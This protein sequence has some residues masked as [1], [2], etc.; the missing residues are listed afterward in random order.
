VSTPLSLL[1]GAELPGP[2]AIENVRRAALDAL[3]AAGWPS[4][5]REAWRYTDLEPLSRASLDLKPSPAAD[6]ALDVARR[7]LHS[8]ATDVRDRALVLVDGRRVATLDT[9]PSHELEV[10]DPAARWSRPQTGNVATLPADR[11]PLAAVNT[12]FTEDGLWLRVPAGRSVDRP[13]HLVVLA[14]GR[15]DLAAQPR[16]V[17][18]VEQDARIALVLHFV[19][20]APGIPGWVNSVTEVHQA[21]RSKLELYRYQ[22]HGAERTH[23]SLLAAKLASD[24]ELTAFYSDLG[25]ALVR[26]DIEVEL[27]GRGASATLNGVF[28]AGAGQHVDNHTV[29]DHAA[30]ET[31]SAEHFRGI[32][33]QRG[34][35][36][37]N[38]KVIVRP[39][40][41]RI[42]A[43]QRSDN[44]LLGEHAEI[45]A[46]PELEIYA[47]DVKCSHGTTVGELDE[48]HLFYLRSRGIGEADARDLLTKAFAAA[49]IELIGDEV[50]RTRALELVTERLRRLE[51]A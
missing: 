14:S 31:R 28:V 41:Q 51:R 48:D 9:L 10:G 21:P 6:E 37:F 8:L 2:A 11:F 29:V 17:V 25:G 40:S 24:A 38:G 43:S 4:R 3:D 19:D 45:D 33:G 13:V 34:R 49:T 5:Q 46:K 36:V 7:A 47:N 42:D 44:L 50:E 18:D 12:A 30:G 27:T 26:N 1:A 39:N 20:S 35:G 15:A 23:T 32:V 16:I 22:R